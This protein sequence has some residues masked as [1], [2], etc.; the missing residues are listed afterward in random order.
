MSPVVTSSSSSEV[1]GIATSGNSDS[2]A[3]LA[4]MAVGV[5]QCS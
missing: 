5:N 3:P 2:P 4:E 1:S